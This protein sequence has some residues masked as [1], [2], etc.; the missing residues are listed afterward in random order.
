M[1]RIVKTTTLGLF[2][3]LLLG[4]AMLACSPGV[5]EA[6]TPW[7][8]TERYR[9]PM[10]A[11]DLSLTLESPGGGSV[12]T[13]W[14]DGSLYAA[15]NN[16]GRYNIRLQNNTGERVEAVVTV[17][18][19][20]VVSGELGNYKRQRGYVIEAYGSVVIEG[21]RQSLDQVAAFRFTDIGNS[22]SARRGSGQHVGV[23]GVAVFKEWQPRRRPAP[24]PIAT[25][26]YYEPYGGGGYDYRNEA[27]KSA[28]EAA[29]DA[30]SPPPASA[31]MGAGKARTA[32][33]DGDGYAERESP[34][35]RSNR[36]GTEYGEST[37]SSVREVSFTRKH[38]RRPDS[39]ITM[40]YD[41][42][43][44]LRARGVPVDPVYYPPYNPPTP[45]PFPADGERHNQYA[46]PP[47]VRRY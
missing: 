28:G 47:P 27:S 16:G 45:Q 21:F 5:A 12:Q 43:E 46:P 23:I 35:A 18:G 7:N 22:Y 24:T 25:R 38:T 41:S 32:Y 40:Y 8:N 42:I 37:Y 14:H 39:L 31:P 2:S 19:R 1:R 29:A 26:P 13:Y 44:G 11:Q 34:R 33:D 10:P 36:L 20:D 9:A 4:A 15:G 3:T 30:S 6:H 17:D